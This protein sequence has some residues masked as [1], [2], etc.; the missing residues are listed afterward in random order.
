MAR[1][2]FTARTDALAR[3]PLRPEH[4]HDTDDDPLLAEAITTAGGFT[5]HAPH[6]SASAATRRAYATRSRTRTT[7]QGVFAGVAPATLSAGPSIPADLRLGADHRAFTSPD[8]LW[9]NLLA[10]SIIDGSDGLSTTR[11][12]TSN[13][14]LLRGGRWE[15]E[16]PSPGGRGR[17]VTIGIRDTEVTAFVLRYCRNGMPA[18]RLLAAVAS[19][20]PQAAPQAG[21]RLVRQLIGHG[22]LLHDLLPD[23]PR[24]D[25]LTHLL[26]RLPSS[27]LLRHRLEQLR[28]HLAGADEHRPGDAKRLHLLTAADAITRDVLPADRV[29]RVDTAADATVVLPADLARRAAEAAGV[30]WR[31]SSGCDPLADY[32][33]RFV[34][35]YGTR[36]AVPLLELLD[37]VIGLGPLD[38]DATDIGAGP[39]DPHGEGVLAHLLA[40][41]LTDGRT[42]ILLDEAIVDRLTNRDEAPPP[43]T[44]EIY[45]HVLPAA[46][47]GADHRF[48]LAVSGGSQDAL[49][50]TGRFL[51]LLRQLPHIPP[52]AGDGHGVLIA[53][54]V[55]RPRSDAVASVAAET[56]LAAHRLPVGVP[57]RPGDLDL[58]DLVVFSAGGCLIV[59]SVT[60]DRPVRPVLYSRI[61]P[62]L[63]PPAARFLAAAG[64]SGERPWHCWSW[65][66]L[67]TAPFTPAVRYRG[68]WLAPARWAL[69]RHLTALAGQRDR[70]Q[71]ALNCWRET[72]RPRPP[73][74][75][76]TDD[77]DRRLPLDLRRADDRELLRRYVRRGL[78]AV[79]APWGAQASS[80]AVLPGPGGCHL[81]E[82]VVSLDRAAPSPALPQ[83]APPVRPP[84]QGLH[85]PG[86][87]WLSLAVQAPSGCHERIL[88]SLAPRAGDLIGRGDR[89][90]WLRYRDLRHGEHL[91]I[92]FHTD[93]AATGTLLASVT[94]WA[95]NLHRQ[96]LISGFCVEPYEQETERYGGREAITAAERFF[97]ADSA[98]ALD[99]LCT[100]REDDARLSVAAACAAAIARRIG[101]DGIAPARLDRP[102][103]RLAHA[104][105]SRTRAA[106]SPWPTAWESALADYAAAL[107]PGIGARV[108]SD[109]I[110]M[111]CNRIAPDSEDIVRAL[112]ADLI[113]TIKET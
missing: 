18:E 8:P 80:S 99:V 10:R 112:A 46:E 69:P 70:W 1:P 95:S 94:G 55:A 78:T 30:L 2:I 98:F 93:P 6:G 113:R 37:P 48:H 56:G 15:I 68:T 50:T 76:A 9:L 104:L 25:P 27:S 24:R 23:D 51:R 29:L 107:P 32:H 41:A 11:V 13:L 43:R 31:I 17:T 109:V 92:R 101:I 12:T 20:W 64:H 5:Q 97:A 105:R 90:F 75:V 16:Q 19:R 58:G 79:T 84:G 83:A 110:H 86:G 66:G 67:T 33:R 100:I 88:Q 57:A 53:E 59:W 7:P 89:W 87:P 36:R 85:L 49:S 96:G 60:R 62:R 54:L 73:D 44:A 74:V 38:D 63:L 81:L 91:R 82:L 111:H 28:D 21:P 14:A 108:A 106:A 35:R 26:D 52:D 42:E 4:G 39:A 72:T 34:T 77:A 22:F 102:T 45:V 3:I 103:H 47:Q 40:D 71:E 61:T 65:R